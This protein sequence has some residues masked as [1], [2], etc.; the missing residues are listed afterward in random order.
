MFPLGSLKT[1]IH[2]SKLVLN[3]ALLLPKV[4]C[5]DFLYQTIRR[6]RS[7]KHL[8]RRKRSGKRRVEP[9]G[10]RT[11]TGTSETATGAS[12]TASVALRTGSLTTR[13]TT[14]RRTS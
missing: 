11:A 2:G 1:P 5:F 14:R 8:G 7:L 6:R 13:G 3:L 10:A 9:G 4:Y 12:G